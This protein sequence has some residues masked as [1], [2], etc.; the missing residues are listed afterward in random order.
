MIELVENGRSVTY[1]VYVMVLSSADYAGRTQ[2]IGHLLLVLKYSQLGNSVI[3]VLNLHR[4]LLL[5]I[6]HYQLSSIFVKEI[7]QVA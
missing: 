7:S 5:K 2:G 1:D 3:K 4:L 6:L